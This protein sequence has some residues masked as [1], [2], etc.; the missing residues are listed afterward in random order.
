MF[1]ITRRERELLGLQLTYSRLKQRGA[2][3]MKMGFCDFCHGQLRLHHTAAITATIPKE[4][5][6]EGVGYKSVGRY[7]CLDHV[8]CNKKLLRT[9]REAKVAA[10]I[11]SVQQNKPLIL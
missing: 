1:L 8:A 6:R 5:L 7:V 9:R 2:M 10:F 3:P 4:K 11:E